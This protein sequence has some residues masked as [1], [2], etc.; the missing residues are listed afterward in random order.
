MRWVFA[1]LLISAPLV[2]MLSGGAQEYAAMSLF[3]WNPFKS[4]WKTADE[5]KGSIDENLY[6]LLSCYAKKNE[7]PEI[8][9]TYGFGKFKYQLRMKNEIVFKIDK[10]KI[11]AAEKMLPLDWKPWY[12]FMRDFREIHGI[13]EVE[14]RCIIDLN[15]THYRVVIAFY[16]NYYLRKTVVMAAD[17]PKDYVYSREHFK[18]QVYG[19][20]VLNVMYKNGTVREN[21]PSS[22]DGFFYYFDKHN[23][24]YVGFAEEF[25]KLIERE[26]LPKNAAIPLS[27]KFANVL[28]TYSTKYDLNNMRAYD[29]VNRNFHKISEP[30]TL[31]RAPYPEQVLWW[32]TLIGGG[33][34][35][36]FSALTSFILGYLGI[37][38]YDVTL[39]VWGTHGVLGVN[40]KDLAGVRGL[41]NNLVYITVQREDGVVLKIY[42]FEVT[43]VRDRN[44]VVPFSLYKDSPYYHMGAEIQI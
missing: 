27:V 6:Y 20:R 3:S 29:P 23:P 40:E 19:C 35:G 16:D 9:K 4:D 13:R 2:A 15:S 24:L 42:L 14:D 36:S 32:N 37:D 39:D 1:A 5:L 34:C 44:Y 31:K 17:T 25:R 12:V 38:A 43:N 21:P 26:K 10:G 7:K 30:E 22:C 41:G 11:Y 18:K 8:V 33:Y 28:I